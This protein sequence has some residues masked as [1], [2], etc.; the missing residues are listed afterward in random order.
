MSHELTL[1]N[2][3]LV[4]RDAV[5]RGTLHVVD[6]TIADVDI[7]RS[8][9]PGA[10][11]VEGDYLLPGLVELHTDVL[12]RHAFPRPNVAWP[13]VPAV[14]G[15]DAELAAAGI[16]TVLDSL[17]VGYV[18]DFGRRPRDPRPLVAA[19]RAT[20]AQGALRAEH[21]L[22]LRCE[23]STENVVADFER[24]VDDTA[25][26]LVSLMD[27]TPGQRQYVDIA[28]YRQFYQG[29]YGVSDDHI[30]AMIAQ[31]LEDRERFGDRHRAA[32]IALC[33]KHGHALAS[34]DDA[35]RAHV[36]EAAAAGT[37]IA[38]FPTTLDAAVAAHDF[39]MA[40]L[41]GAPNLVCGKSHSGNI[42]VAELASA[43]RLDI[44]SSDYVP[45]SLLHGAFVLH[46]MGIALPDAVATVTATPAGRVGLID[47]GA[48]APGL[49]GDVVRVRATSSTVLVAG[50]WRGGLRVG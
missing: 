50:V 29:K 17:A 31:R 28:R 7:G 32:L 6:G 20:Q 25:V 11:D 37:V 9:P 3:R 35:T 4:L 30:E 18:F 16:T 48:L 24:L 26:R 15:Y 2:G 12:E 42:A 23:V 43:G 8:V 39:G 1:A 44:L 46:A 10:I 36:E 47:R 49:R 33:H 5:V 14:L 13:E 45:S 19:V 40:V 34:H 38:E 22:H 41:A 27:H 21:Y